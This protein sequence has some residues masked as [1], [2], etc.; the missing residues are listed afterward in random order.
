MQR[1]KRQATWT[2]LYYSQ[3]WNLLSSSAIY[4]HETYTFNVQFKDSATLSQ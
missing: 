1:S 4:K 3:S 2:L